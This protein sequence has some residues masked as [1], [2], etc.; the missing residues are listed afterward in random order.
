[1]WLWRAPRHQSITVLA[2]VCVLGEQ[3]T[4]VAMAV[5]VVCVYVVKLTKAILH[6]CG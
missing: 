2:A 4:D 6:G 5:A 1:M 3:A